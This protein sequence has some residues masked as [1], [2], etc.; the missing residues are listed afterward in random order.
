MASGVDEVG[1]ARRAELPNAT[2][3]NSWLV[4][5][6]GLCA[7]ELCALGLCV[8]GLSAC[9]GDPGRPG[10]LPEP[11]VSKVAP[12]VDDGG[13]SAGGAGLSGPFAALG[14]SCPDPLPPSLRCGDD[15]RVVA[16][17]DDAYAIEHRSM[18]AELLHERHASDTKRAGIDVY[19]DSGVAWLQV[20]E[21]GSCATLVG[22]TF[23]G[24]PEGMNGP[25]L[26]ELIRK[27]D[28][29]E[30]TTLVSRA[31]WE[32]AGWADA[33][34]SLIGDKEPSASP[35]SPAPKADKPKADKPKA[36]KPAKGDE[37][38]D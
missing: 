25:Q 36:D 21:C 6:L 8:L 24:I 5:A 33:F 13:A 14:R 35:S 17:Y 15:G 23:A 34:Q 31:D 18:S 9:G 37:T 4:S 10:G 22:W 27:L 32:Q 38:Y 2:R 20:L 26:Q 11:D 7:L 28:L 16:V 3:M 29:P 12:P 30:N 19:W 1:A